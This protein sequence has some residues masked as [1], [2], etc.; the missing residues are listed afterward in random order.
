MSDAPKRSRG[1]PP[2]QRTAEEKRLRKAQYNRE[3]YWN[4]R[5]QPPVESAEDEPII[6]PPLAFAGPAAMPIPIDPSGSSGPSGPAVPI[7]DFIPL[8]SDNE[9]LPNFQFEDDDDI[10]STHASSYGHGGHTVDGSGGGHID[11]DIY[12]VSDGDQEVDGSGGRHIDED[13]YGVLDGDQEVRRLP[14]ETTE[15][16]DQN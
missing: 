4:L 13:T 9:S 5:S 2:Q 10:P 16:Q 7:E 12:R 3:L 11:E 6:A 1:R 8:I 14:K 15:F